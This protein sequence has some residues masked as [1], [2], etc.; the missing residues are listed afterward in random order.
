M[1]GPM[2]HAHTVP[3]MIRGV[4]G[5]EVAEIFRFIIRMIAAEGTQAQRC[6]KSFTHCFQNRLPVA[7]VQNRMF[8]EKARS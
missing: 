6:Q 4:P 7:F 1:N 3:L 2:S 5:T 8:S